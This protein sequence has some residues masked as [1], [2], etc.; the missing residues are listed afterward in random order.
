M[1]DLNIEGIANELDI[2]IKEFMEQTPIPYETINTTYEAA[3]RTG[4]TKKKINKD[5]CLK[6]IRIYIRTLINIFNIELYKNS[7][8]KIHKYCILD[9]V[10][11]RK[12]NHHATAGGI[13]INIACVCGPFFEYKR[14][15]KHPIIGDYMHASFQEHLFLLAAH[16]YAHMFAMNYYDW[17]NNEKLRIKPHGKEWQYIYKILRNYTNKFLST[18]GVGKTK[19]K[20]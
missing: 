4:I 11:N 18:N 14:I 20:I 5:T 15:E 17:E 8:I 12:N 6:E 7:K 9:L 19:W 13:Q 3:H 16:E 1:K 10:K 2:Q